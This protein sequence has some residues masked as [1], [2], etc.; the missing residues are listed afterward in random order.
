MQPAKQ[1]SL[2]FKF[3]PAVICHFDQLSESRD[4]KVLGKVMLYVKATTP[5]FLVSLKVINA[6]LNPAKPVAK[7]LRGIKKLFWL[8]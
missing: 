5:G 8:H 6:T 4:G 7:K 2:V 3:Y 1:C